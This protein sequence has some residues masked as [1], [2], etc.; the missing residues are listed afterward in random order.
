MLVIDFGALPPEV[1]SG[2]LYLGPGSGPM[3]AAA[4]A[5]DGLAAELGSAARAYE[6]VVSGLASDEWT[7]PAS[8]SMAGAAAP[9]VAWMSTSA[10]QAEQTATQARA[11]ATAYETAFS[12]TVPPPAIAANRAQLH[13]LVATNFFGQNS[14]AIAA[15]EAQYGEMWAQDAAAMYGYA[16]ASSS[17]ATVAPFSAPP[18]TTTLDAK[19][20]QS[21]GVAKAAATPA[22]TAGKTATA[23]VQQ[24]SSAATT[25]TSS[26]TTTTTTAT[27]PLT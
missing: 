2:R 27:D 7:G 8:E 6:S 23:A 5:W 14:P 26:A 19:L 22:G 11:A 17:A 20:A 3:L 12:A 25:T 9:C 21:D 13:A 1:N 16:A 18:Q 15:T 4:T 24:V 10:V